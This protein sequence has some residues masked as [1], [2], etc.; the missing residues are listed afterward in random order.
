[1]K[2]IKK[3]KRKKH[4]KRSMVYT[5]INLL[6]LTK[7]NLMKKKL[8]RKRKVKTAQMIHLRPEKK[9]KM[10]KRGWQISGKKNKIR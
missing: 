2:N 10:R 4:F 9:E 5:I 1:M 6:I 8:K 7:K 3:E